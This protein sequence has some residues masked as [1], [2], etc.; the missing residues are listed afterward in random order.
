MR[1][2]LRGDCT[3]ASQKRI[4][5]NPSIFV[6][7]GRLAIAAK[8]WHESIVPIRSSQTVPAGI[9]G[10]RIT[11][12]THDHPRKSF[13]LPSLR[14]RGDTVMTKSKSVVQSYEWP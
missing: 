8:G 7:E 2:S 12:G 3:A 5:A 13:L 1:N 6:F 14:D 4:L 10:P 11:Q 9:P